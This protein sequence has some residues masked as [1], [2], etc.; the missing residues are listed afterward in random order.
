VK[1][2]TIGVHFVGVNNTLLGFNRSGV[3]AVRTYEASALQYTFPFE[4][5]LTGLKHQSEFAIGSDRVDGRSHSVVNTVW[6]S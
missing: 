4:N 1:R 6:S 5:S 3:V 2:S